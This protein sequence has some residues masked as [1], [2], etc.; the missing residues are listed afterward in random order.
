MRVRIVSSSTGFEQRLM[1]ENMLKRILIATAMAGMVMAPAAF[2]QAPKKAEAP[3]QI[4][5]PAG[6]LNQA[7]DKLI[8][9]AGVQIMY[10]PSLTAGIKVPAVS[11]ALTL[12][13]ALTKLLVNTGLKADT[14]DD[15]MVV[16]RKAQS[17]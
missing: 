12:E 16:V 14:T 4:N 17:S 3:R 5:I 1:G 15:K 7:L 13:E 6:S 10:E 11:G 8:D 9:Q 2:A